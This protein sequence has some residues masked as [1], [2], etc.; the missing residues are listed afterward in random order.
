VGEREALGGEQSAA[1]REGDLVARLRERLAV[2]VVELYGQRDAS[3]SGGLRARGRER[4]L[5][6]AGVLRLLGLLLFGFFVRREGHGDVPE[7]L[8][9]VVLAQVGADRHGA[10]ARG[11]VRARGAVR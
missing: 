1:G 5:G 11:E 8:A 9:A 3:A 10:G 6:G 7:L 2:L 4:R